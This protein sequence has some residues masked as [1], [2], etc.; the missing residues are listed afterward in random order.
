MWRRITAFLTLAVLVLGLATTTALAKSDNSQGNNGNNGK[1]IEKLS[2]KFKDMDEFGWGLSEVVKMAAKGVLKG[3]GDGVFAPGAKIT[4]QEAA[5]AIVRLMDEEDTADD[6]TSAQVEAALDGIDDADRIADWARKPVAY[7]ARRGVLDEPL[8]FRPLADATRLDVAVLMTRAVGFESEALAKMDN[9]LEFKDAHLIPADF[10]GYV[11]VATDHELITGYDDRTFRPHQA[12]KRVEMAVML[13]RA[14]GLYDRDRE[15]EL[16]GIIRSINVNDNSFVLKVGDRSMTLEL[17]DEASIFV[18][19]Q[20]MTLADLEIGMQAEVKLDLHGRVIFIEA[21][22][23]AEPKELT[24]EGTITSLKAATSTSLALVGINNK[25]YPLSTTAVVKLDGLTAVFADLEIGD[26]VKALVRQGLVVKLEAA[27]ADTIVIGTI[28]ALTAPTSTAPAKVTVKV[29]D[30]GTTTNTRY[31]LDAD[32]AIWVEGY[33]AE[34]SDLR[35]GDQVTLTLVAGKVIMIDAERTL[36]TVEGNLT[37]VRLPSATQAAYIKVAVVTDGSTSITGYTVNADAPVSVNGE[38]AVF[39]DLRVGDAVV[40]IVASGV[41]DQIDATRS[42]ET[43]LDGSIAGLS[44]STTTSAV[45]RISVGYVVSGSFTLKTFTVNT[46]TVIRV[47]GQS[48][49]FGDLRLND[50]VTLHLQGDALM[51]VEA[52]R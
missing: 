40:L 6:M 3:K 20:E 31:T 2:E 39:A 18:G 25:T 26:H 52:A 9:D 34:F 50:L 21:R 23:I 38:A 46:S 4:Q 37:E 19:N 24:V 42:S 47:N 36:V 30:D 17:A 7:L 29:T 27:R 41:V 32:A 10:I 15:D 45:G 8:A 33:V 51:K 5:V 49:D 48:A 13:G 11:A 43:L 14:D 22:P 1:K 12:V 44:L 16:K 28:S 35:V